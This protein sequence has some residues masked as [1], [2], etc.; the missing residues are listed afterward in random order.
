MAVETKHPQKRLV[1]RR[2]LLSTAGK[3]GGG[4]IALAAAG[5]A[6][7]RWPH[8]AKPAPTPTATPN[9]ASSAANVDT[10]VSRPDL[11]PPHVTITHGPRA[12]AA[13]S[14]APS[15]IFV[16]PRGYTTNGPG[17]AGP[18]ILD[19]EGRLVW[20]QHVTQFPMN[21]QVQRY[22]GKPVL[23]WWEGTILNGYGEGNGVIYDSS[24]RQIATVKAG[25]GLQV[26]LHEF[27]LTPQD[28]ALITAYHPTTADL[29]P[30]GGSQQGQVLDCV[31][32]EVDV[33]SGKVLFEWRSLDHVGVDETYNTLPSSGPFDYFHINSIAVAP[34]GNLIISARN[35]WTVYKISRQSGQILWR[36]GGKRSDFTMDS[37]AR[38]F[39]Q[40][41]ARPQ[42]AN[43]I[44]LF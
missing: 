39:W 34:D 26:D 37:G 3:A 20:F 18:M 25:N 31:A 21:L 17:Q 35:T 8:A 12:F 27:L 9:P 10:F 16:A 42:G 43:Q 28:T 33:A 32:Q 6:G 5:Y 29:S 23:T 2:H 44:T 7:Y 41:D 40:H 15:Y 11:S 1:S 24:Y 36:L 19:T 13:G 30:V 4:I 38:F 22:Q 14:G